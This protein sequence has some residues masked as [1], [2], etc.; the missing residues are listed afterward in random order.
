MSK[1][2]W[3]RNYVAISLIIKIISRVFTKYYSANMIDPLEK[4]NEEIEEFE[5]FVDDFGTF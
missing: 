5:E 2:S 1:I 3:L 4:I